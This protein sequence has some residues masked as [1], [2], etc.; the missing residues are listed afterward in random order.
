[1][2][3]SL[4]DR[5][6]NVLYR[7]D[8]FIVPWAEAAEFLVRDY[9]ATADAVIRE[10]NP[11]TACNSGCVWQIPNRFQDMTDTQKRLLRSEGR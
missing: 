9:L 6:A 3:D 8:G 5:I 10:L 7:R 11:A 1:M 2:S 4:R